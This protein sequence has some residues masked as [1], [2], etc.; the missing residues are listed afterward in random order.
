MRISRD[1]YA[2]LYG[3]TAGDRFRLADTD[4]VCE[5]ER[6]LGVPGE[7]AVFGGGKTIRDGMAQSQRS[8]A[9]GALDLVIT[10]VVVMD[11]VLGIVKGDLGVKNGRIVGVGKAGN[12]DTQDGVTPT[13]AIGPGTEVIAGEHLI[14]T[15]GGIDS[16]IHMICPQQVYEALSNGITTII[17]GGTG[18]ADGTAATTCTPGPWNISR[19]LQ[20]VDNLPLNVGILGK[21]NASRT[22]PLIEQIVAG[23][24]GLK[25]H[26]DWGTTPSAIDTSLRVADDYDIQVAIH[27]DTLNESGFVEDTIA[28]IGGR[29]IH[30]YHTEGAGGGHAPDIIK[31]AGELNALPSSTNPTRPYTVNTLDEHLDMLMVCHHLNPAVPEDVAFAESRIRAETIAAEDVLHDLGVISMYS[32]DSQ[33][34]GRIGE[35]YAKLYQTADK[36]KRMG[37]PPPGSVSTNDNLRILR[38]LAKLTINPAITHGIAHEVGSLE[39]G[40]LADIV[41]WP[42]AFFGA[43]PKMIVKGGLIAWSVMGDPNASIPTTEPVL[44]RPMWGAFGSAPAATSVTFTSQAALDD[45]VGERLR[46]NKR[47]VAVKGCRTV[48]KKQMLL[49]DL[50]PKIEVDP[51]TYVVR[52]DGKIATVGPAERLSHTQLFYL[53]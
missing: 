53:M 33:A 16:H 41:L 45:G 46:L 7:E 22:A 9:E 31:I 48:T 30:T 1:R 19:M 42:I 6:D 15:P 11:P 12:P 39:A 44:Y 4:L 34:M 40:K 13:M 27:T 35:S 37:E 50:T 5:V 38:Y 43:K 36:M 2:R 25:D 20:A 26:E 32:S 14:A 49:N 47:L 18:P 23:A 3:P 51:E 17:G 24:C 52:V 28:A 8:S 21:G 29:T 10:N